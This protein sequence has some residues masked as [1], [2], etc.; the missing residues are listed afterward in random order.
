MVLGLTARLSR[1]RKR[2]IILVKENYC[3]ERKFTEFDKAT[4]SVRYEEKETT[5]QYILNHAP[6]D[7]AISYIMQFIHQTNES[8]FT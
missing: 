2:K 5:L 6:P 1:F 4:L 3:D 7:R 8:R